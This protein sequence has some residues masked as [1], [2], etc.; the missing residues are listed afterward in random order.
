MRCPWMGGQLYH[1]ELFRASEEFLILTAVR[2]LGREQFHIKKCYSD[3]SATGAQ[4]TPIKS[5]KV[6]GR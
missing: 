2:R 3:A 4:P 1:D 5:R 6:L